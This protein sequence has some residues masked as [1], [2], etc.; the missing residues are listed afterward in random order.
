MSRTDL[1]GFAEDHGFDLGALPYTGRVLLESLLRSGD[2]ER[3]AVLGKRLAAGEEPG[4]EMEFR[5]ARILVQDYT[6]IPL[7]V[8]LAALRDRVAVPGR[9][10]PALPIDVVVDHSVQTDWAGRPDALGLN[11]ALEMSRNQE[12]YAFLKWAEGAFH[13]LRVIPPGRG[14]VHQV[15]LERLATVVA[16]GADGTLFP[17]TV[18]GTD[19]HTTMVNGLGVLGWGVGG[20]EAEAQMLGLAQPLRVPAIVGVRLTGAVSPGTSPTDVVL[21]LTKRLREENVRALMLEF[22]GPGVAAL[23]AP[24][25][26]TIANMAPEY[27]AMSAFFPVDEETLDYLRRTG[28]TE[29]AIARVRDYCRTQRL[30]RDGP[31]PV[32]GRTI[33][34]DL[35]RVGPS[36]AGPSR[37]DQRISLG[38]LPSSFEA[39]LSGEVRGEAGILDGDLVI[40]AITSCTSTSN[41]KAMLA[42]GLLARRA[43]ERGL[44]VP[45]HVKTSL[46][47]GSRAVTRYLEDSGLLPDLEKL[48]FHVAGY[49]C[50]TCNGGSGPLNPGVGE[51]V[52]RAGLTVAAVLSGNRNFESRVHSQVRAGYLASP[53]LVVALALAGTVR[54]DLE[55]EPLGTDPG[56]APVYLRDLWPHSGELQQLEDEFITPE[57]F[58]QDEAPGAAWQAI[59]ASDGEV[60]AWDESSTYIRP[61]VYVDPAPALASMTGARALLA[62]GDDISTDH[63]S[64]VGAIPA[65]SPAGRHLAEREVRDF[66]SYGSRRGNHEVMARGAFSN[67]RLRNHLVGEG[68]SGGTTLHLPSGERL[69]VFEAA[70]RYAADGTPLVVLAGHS[71]GM[72]SS[73]DWAAKGPWLLGVRA[74]L[75]ESFERIHRANLC[76]M[77]IL[78]LLLPQGWAALGLT[79]HEKFALDLDRMRETGEVRVTAG[80]KDFTVRTDVPSAGEWDVLLAGG[81]LPFLLQRLRAEGEAG[82]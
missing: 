17:D 35:G 51:A 7:L 23:S 55:N 16:E 25:R 21:G 75:A 59:T 73:R 12:R 63:I 82:R 31:E 34:F 80:G 42:A 58:A 27:G 24:D 43:V 69:P 33:D 32:F 26:C 53:A 37:P 68:D 18:I 46:S 56:G 44:N 38:E 65:G 11:E 28:R 79:G 19:S 77:G 29:A 8:D 64:P 45:A 30:L 40:A 41:P 74:V 22:T 20:L 57:V 47:P 3:A 70:E 67:P 72:G 15:N 61:P 49:G 50:M 4:L 66:N 76:A 2:P 6:G 36:L 52:D 14:I 48:G 62:L 81:T 78:P 10:N 71:Y 39:L 1:P 5:P 13:G 54:A 9:V 60:F